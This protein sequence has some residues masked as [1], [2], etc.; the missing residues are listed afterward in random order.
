MSR[1][2]LKVLEEKAREFEIEFDRSELNAGWKD[3]SDFLKKYPYRERPELIDELTPD[4][5]Y[6]K[7]AKDYFFLWI[8]HKTRSLGAIFTYGG[9]VYP[10]AVA[11]IDIFK[12][13]L[14]IVVD[15][16]RRLSEK[17]DAEWDRIKG[18]GGDRL[19]AKKI[20]F[21]YYPKEVLPIFKT[22]HLEYF[23]R[24]LE[25]NL[26]EC[27][28]EYWNKSYKDLSIG[29]KYELL[30][31]LLLR[32]KK[33]VDRMKDWDNA[34]F[35]RFLYHTYPIKK[36]SKMIPKK[37]IKPL[38]QEWRMLFE[39]IDELGVAFLFAMY[40]KELGFPYIVK[41]SN[42]FPDV[43]AIDKNGESVTIELEYRASDFIAHGHAQDECDYIVC[44][45]NDLEAA[46]EGFP[47]IIALKDKLKERS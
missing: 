33:S 6:K 25:Y 13:L 18:F 23:A 11:K 31:E 27:A 36:L 7:G 40:H 35:A 24:S 8:E 37:A 45:E 43:T 26:D 19:I 29:E 16:S 39:P 21:L 17:I 1:N 20:V 41:V 10:N 12:S 34:Y 2:L 3:H 42:K 28:K 14:K 38:I 4:K 46:L 9:S 5:L 22:E 30:N 32:I 15:D 44:W 47:Q